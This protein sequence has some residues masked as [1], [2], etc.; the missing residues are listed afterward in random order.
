MKR[1]EMLAAASGF[2]AAVLPGAALAQGV[3]S[4]MDAGRQIIDL[5]KY[6]LPVGPKKERFNDFLRD[7]AIPALNRLG[8]K[9]VGV[10]IVLY[11]ANVPS[12]T[13]YILLPY[14]SLEA[15]SAAKERLA[16]DTIFLEAGAP[17]LDCPI[18]DPA[19]LRAESTLLRAFKNMPTVETPPQTTGNKPRLFEMRTYE[20]HSVKAGMK[21]I[22]MFNEGGEIE[23]FR[24][25]S[26]NPV[27]FGET[28]TG[29]Q[30]P[31]LTYMLCHDN[32]ET[33][34]ANWG[35]FAQDP[36]WLKLREMEKYKDTVSN[37]T[38]IILRPTDYSQI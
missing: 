7:A 9:P 38:D 17:V 30:M 32:M 2:A 3:G 21:K 8:V 13:L 18:L 10:F 33:R 1:R 31:S 26:L 35:K 19:F 23:I 15:W 6:Y 4:K 36:D 34:D 16:V 22:E 28:L 14:D 5:R 37:I 24:R 27:F 29:T 11:G 20:S 12:P 25:T